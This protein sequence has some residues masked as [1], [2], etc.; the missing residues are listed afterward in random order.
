MR[1]VRVVRLEVVASVKGGDLAERSQRP[2]A[3]KP[4]QVPRWTR[5]GALRSGAFGLVRF[6]VGTCVS[7]GRAG[8]SCG[9][10]HRHLSSAGE[11]RSGQ[12]CPLSGLL[13]PRPAPVLIALGIL[14][15]VL[16]VDLAFSAVATTCA[17]FTRR[18]M[19]SWPFSHCGPRTN[20]GLWRARVA[21]VWTIRRFSW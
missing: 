21:W 19:M 16:A 3:A 1:V 11:V 7:F 20:I 8:A 6:S 17:Y 15:A 14:R 18:T 13:E 12:E 2:R 5:L 9:T 10:R 4:V